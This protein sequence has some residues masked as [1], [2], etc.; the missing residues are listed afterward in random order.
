MSLCGP[1]EPTTE[2]EH[3]E[4]G[5]KPTG[6]IESHRDQSSNMIFL[7]LHDVNNYI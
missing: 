3:H 2:Q 4:N 6:A 1:L 7:T 5:I